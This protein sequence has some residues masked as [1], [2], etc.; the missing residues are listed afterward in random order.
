MDHI[1]N[2]LSKNAEIESTSSKATKTPPDNIRHNPEKMNA[3]KA[4]PPK[5][6]LIVK[7]DI[8]SKKN[9]ENRVKK[10]S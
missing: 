7:K 8:S 6:V 5:A 1:T 3:V 2:L 9:E 10:D 4:P